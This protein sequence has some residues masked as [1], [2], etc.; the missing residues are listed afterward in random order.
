M[1]LQIR[2]YVISLFVL[3]SLLAIEL[4]SCDNT[5]PGTNAFDIGSE[6]PPG[7]EASGATYLP[8]I[9]AVATVSDNGQVAYVYLSGDLCFLRDY[10]NNFYDLEAVAT[11]PK[12]SPL[13]V[14]N[15]WPPQIIEVDLDSGLM[16]RSWNVSIPGVLN[17]GIE[18]LTYIPLN[19][20]TGYFYVGD[21]YDGMIYIFL[22]NYDIE[23]YR[24][25][26]LLEPVVTLDLVQ[27]RD[28]LSGMHWDEYNSL[29][30]CLFGDGN[31]VYTFSASRNITSDPNSNINNWILQ[32]HFTDVPGLNQEGITM[33]GLSAQYLVISEDEET[34]YDERLVRYDISL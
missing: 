13:F 14:A 17:T 24:N 10:N 11:G 15:E 34:Y 25:G 8:S 33:A 30:W 29:L 23:V 21:Q 6:L 26:T 31:D 3:F 5:W 1:F 18:S 28:D 7:F 27:G 16:L 9:D 2:N 4:A 20:T 22:F 19:S 12:V 32:S